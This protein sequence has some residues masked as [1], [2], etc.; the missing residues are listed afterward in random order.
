MFEHFTLRHL[1]PL[2]LSTAITMGSFTPFTRDPEYAIR[3]FGFPNDIAASRAAWPLIK[4]GSART[5]INCL[6][7]VLPNVS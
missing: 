1:P 2:L 4:V 7:Y 5:Q 6:A 3:L